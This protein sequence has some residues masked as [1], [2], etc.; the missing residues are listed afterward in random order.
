MVKSR[1]CGAVMS[2]SHSEESRNSDSDAVLFLRPISNTELL[3]AQLIWTSWQLDIVLYVKIV[4][5]RIPVGMWTTCWKCNSQRLA[6]VVAKNSFFHWSK[7][8]LLPWMFRVH[9]PS[10]LWASVLLCI[11]TYINIWKPVYYSYLYQYLIF[12][13]AWNP[14]DGSR[15][16]LADQ[17]LQMLWE[18]GGQDPFHHPYVHPSYQCHLYIFKE[19]KITCTKLNRYNEKTVKKKKGEEITCT[20]LDRYN[21]KTVNKKKRWRIGDFC[22]MG[23]I[24]FASAMKWCQCYSPK[25]I[26]PPQ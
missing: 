7:P 9:S 3:I 17:G 1:M 25:N 5:L 20:K 13:E 19:K 12:W 24:I 14:D 23:N 10:K 2:W 11:F 15:S 21:E 18:S 26:L 4:L 8:L 16:L 22:W 6:L